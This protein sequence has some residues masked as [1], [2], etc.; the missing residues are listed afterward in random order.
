MISRQMRSRQMKMR[1]ANEYTIAE[2]EST[3]LEHAD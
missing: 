1:L 3:L 2:L